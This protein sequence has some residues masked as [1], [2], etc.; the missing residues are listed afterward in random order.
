L[1]GWNIWAA[2]EFEVGQGAV[3]RHKIRT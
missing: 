3:Q 2:C 1:G